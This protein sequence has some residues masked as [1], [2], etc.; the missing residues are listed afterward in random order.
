MTNNID[1]TR[2]A[3]L[4]PAK[5]V[6]IKAGSGILTGKSGLNSKTIENLPRY[7]GNF[8]IL[9]RYILRS[10]KKS[11]SAKGPLPYQNSRQLLP[12]VRASS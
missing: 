3:L 6:V 11:V 5:R 12:W 10:E 4:K 8:C 1:K 9:R 2:K 7:R